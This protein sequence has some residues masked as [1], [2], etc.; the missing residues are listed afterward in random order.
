MNI[1]KPPAYKSVDM[2]PLETTEKCLLGPIQQ[3][4]VA[5]SL[6]FILD[7]YRLYI[8]SLEGKFISEVGSKGQGP[9]DYIGISAYYVDK[10]NHCV[11]IFDNFLSSQIKYDFAGK[12]I[13]SQKRPEISKWINSIRKDRNGDFLMCF[14]VN[15]QE[16][17][18]Y[19]VM[20]DNRI[21]PVFAF[22]PITVTDHMFPISLQ[23]QSMA[24]IN[25]DIDF[26][27][28]LCDTIFSFSEGVIKAKYIVDTPQPMAPRSHIETS[29]KKPFSLFLLKY[30]QEGYFCGFSNIFETKDKILLRCQPEGIL[31]GFYLG[32]KNTLEGNYYVLNFPED[33]VDVPMFPIICAFD[34]VFVAQFEVQNLIGIRTVINPKNPLNEVIDKLDEE[35]NPVLFFYYM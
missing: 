32:D 5:D 30:G 24:E 21:T 31:E 1:T 20:K 8:F 26:I 18:A 23:K 14:S 29:L 35:D 11:N 22:G 25:G 7:S 28:P 33:L 27:M 16:D 13:S 34:N 3:I 19:R 15:P 10:Q 9:T 12:F 4:Q 6:L 2:V 17:I